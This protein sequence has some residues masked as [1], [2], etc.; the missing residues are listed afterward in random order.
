MFAQALKALA[1]VCLFC[2]AAVFFCLGIC[3]EIGAFPGFWI[4]DNVSSQFLKLFGALVSITC[5]LFWSGL[6]ILLAFILVD[7]ALMMFG[8]R[9]NWDKWAG[10][11]SPKS[12]KLGGVLCQKKNALS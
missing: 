2:L 9:F 10:K 11:H 6:M 3:A 5:A 4:M 12:I 8:K 1:S 7:L